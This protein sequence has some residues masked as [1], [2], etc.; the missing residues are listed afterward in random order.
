VRGVG[1]SN[2]QYSTF[3]TRCT[4]KGFPFGGLS[5]ARSLDIW[6]GMRGLDAIGMKKV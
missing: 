2:G 6:N 1:W 4:M 3:T 5:F